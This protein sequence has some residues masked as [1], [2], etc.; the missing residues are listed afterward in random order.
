MSYDKAHAQELG[1]DCDNCPLRNSGK[2]VPSDGPSHADI[3]FVGEA[4]GANEAREGKPFIGPSG[5]LLQIV[6][7]QYGIKR[8]EVFLTNATLCRPVDG[9]NP[10]KS[11]ILACR[12]RLHKELSDRETKSVVAL[13]N[14]A[15]LSILGVEGVT[16]LRVGPGRR[17]PYEPLEGMRIIPTV[18]PAACLRQSDMF[19]SLVA[20]VGK[21]VTEPPEWRPPNFTV[22]DEPASAILALE[23]LAKR[24]AELVIDIEVDIDKETSYDHP[25]RYGL[26]STGLAWSKYAAIVIGEEALKDEA[27]LDALDECLKA[28]KIIAHNGKFDLGGLFPVLGAHTL[29]FDTMLASYCLDERTTGIHGLKTLA[30]EH[31]GAPRYDEEIKRYV[32]PSD[33][34]GNIP[35]PLLYKYNAYDATCTYH[36]YELFKERLDAQGLRELHD[37]LVEASNELMFMELNG[38]AVDRAYSDELSDKYIDSLGVIEERIGANL[39]EAG[40]VPINPRSPKQVKEALAHFR[41]TVESTN[42]DTLKLLQTRATN[43]HLIKFLEEMLLHRREAKMYGTYVKGIRKRMFQG[44]VYSTYKLHGTT[45]GRLASR[46][47]NLQNIAREGAIKQQFIPAKE[48]NVFVNAD[49]AQAELRVL[50]WLAQE[51]YFQEILDDPTRDLFD[52]LTPQLYGEKFVKEAVGVMEGLDEERWKDIRVRVK[53]FVYGLSY[54]RHWSSIATEYK[55]LPKMAQE[56]SRRFFSTIPNVVQFQKDV[57]AQVREGKDLISPFG[58][59]RR[60]HLITDDNWKAI[61]NE[62]LAFLP[63]STSSDVCLRAMVRVRRDLRGSGAFIRNIVHDNLLVDCPSDMAS[64][65]AVLLDRRMVESGQ[66]LVGDYVQFKTDIKI[67]PHWGAV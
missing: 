8:E 21:L 37:F 15:A 64:D 55:M 20:D 56:M 18:H 26:L 28:S 44:R 6:N 36:L 2:F 17:S 52:E 50:A 9:S 46:N 22:F 42:E 53:A 30:V 51:P 29:Y 63:Q 4:P 31:L 61:Q 14:S 40:Y 57:K 45:T 5:R 34:Y 24:Q 27:V 60:F 33:G 35:R 43:E 16:K 49:Y 58:R 32:G 62:A 19:P 48:G 3:A 25:N 47:P 11:A 1:A 66:E 67:G 7:N 59:H 38:I 39:S 12:P 23:Q 54:G 41:V 10:P 65:V 13:G